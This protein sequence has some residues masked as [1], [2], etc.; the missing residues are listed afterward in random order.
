[1]ELAGGLRKGDL[2]QYKGT[3]C[4]VFGPPARKAL[5]K[6]SVAVRTD[7]GRII[8]A[9]IADLTSLGQPE[10][11]AAA[12]D[13]QL[14]NGELD[15]RYADE[16]K[17]VEDLRGYGIGNRSLD[18]RHAAKPLGGEIEAGYGI[19]NRHLQEQPPDGGPAIEVLAQLDLLGGKM[20]SVESSAQQVYDQLC[21][22]QISPGEAHAELAQIEAEAQRVEAALDS[23]QINEMP[24]PS[25]QAVD[26]KGE[27]LQRLD[28]FFANMDSLFQELSGSPPAAAM[29]TSRPP[30]SGSNI[31]KGLPLEPL[32]GDFAK[33]DRVVCTD[34]RRGT[35]AGKP[36]RAAL[37]K[38]SVAVLYDD[39]M[40]EDVR[41]A[42][43]SFA[44]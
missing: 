18:D 40:L 14:G 25:E 19:G 11:I 34:N 41:I 4:T 32:A 36:S 28:N 21:D 31:T 9:R 30:S 5:A 8:D 27:I 24:E 6:L 43:L 2:V 26:L 44:P 29:A 7:D 20:F 37:S 1:M 38:I 16:P 10:P 17:V 42:N 12:G 35:V 3:A 33:G 23:I 15:N 13:Q 39:G 22:G